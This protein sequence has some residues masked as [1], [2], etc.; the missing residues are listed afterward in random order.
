[1]SQQKKQKTKSRT[2]PEVLTLLA[3][4]NARFSVN[5]LSAFSDLSAGNLD[6]LAKAWPGLSA[7]QK[8]YLFEGLYLHSQEDFVKDFSAMGFFGLKDV[9]P[10][11]RRYALGLLLDCRQPSFID[12]VVNVAEKDP[13]PDVRQAAI[14]ILGQFV[15]DLEL[16]VLP[17]EAGAK[18]LR[19]LESLK[20]DPDQR[21][22]WRTM[23]ALAY[24]DHPLVPEMIRSA[25]SGENEEQLISG[26][27]AIQH[28]LNKRWADTVLE[29]LDHPDL[30]VQVEAIKAAGMIPVRQAKKAI[31]KLLTVFDELDSDVLDAAILAISQIGGAQA[32]E[33]ID[34]LAE[35]FEDDEEM[36]E[37]FAVAK[38]NFETDEFARQFFTKE[39][40]QE[41]F[42]WEDAENEVS[43]EDEDSVEDYVSLIRERIAQLPASDE[44]LDDDPAVHSHPHAH[45]HDHD[46][47]HDEDDDDE[48]SFDWDHFRI[49]D[50]ISAEDDFLNDD[51]FW[52]NDKYSS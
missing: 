3:K 2:F 9:N 44:D 20:D 33:I 42:D 11:I 40:L 35:V 8:N 45:S 16:D 21:I 4:E 15:V 19:V 1:M 27:R 6:L 38:D 43:S 36:Q 7:V 17:E 14:E 46:H 32:Q 28:S 51:S 48:E 34:E 18:T 10:D 26:L 47:A 49:I 29:Y 31:F 12:L 13:D 37:L 22:R 23:E 52:E 39:E 41:L 24:M 30:D 50:D 5:D 25:L